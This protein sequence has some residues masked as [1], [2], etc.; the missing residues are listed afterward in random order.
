VMN[1]W[2]LDVFICFSSFFQRPSPTVT[3]HCRGVANDVRRS[4]RDTRGDLLEN[5]QISYS[6]HISFFVS[7]YSN[8]TTSV[9]IIDII[10][11]LILYSI[12]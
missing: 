5:S 3:G 12:E 9:D 11:I 2:D 7:Y 4:R 1:Q 10:V 6:Y 8:G